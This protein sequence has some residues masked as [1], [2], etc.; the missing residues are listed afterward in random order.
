MAITHTDRGWNDLMVAMVE[1]DHIAALKVLVAF[2]IMCWRRKI[3][4]ENGFSTPN[5]AKTFPILYISQI[6]TQLLT[7]MHHIDMTE[8]TP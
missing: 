8:L 6:Y 1:L 3:H 5:R 7:H 4:H 2:D